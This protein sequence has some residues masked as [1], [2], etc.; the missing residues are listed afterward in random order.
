[1]K[2]R[3]VSPWISALGVVVVLGLCGLALWISRPEPPRE[4]APEPE[5]TPVAVRELL[6]AE[7]LRLLWIYGDTEPRRRALPAAERSGR[8]VWRHEAL[9]TGGRVEAGEEILR[10]ERKPAELELQDAEAGLAMARARAEQ[11]RADRDGLARSLENARAR[12]ALAERELERQRGLAASGDTAPSVV[13]QTEAAWLAAA[14]RVEQLE[15]QLASAEAALAVA[16]AGVAQARARLDRAQ[17]QLERTVLHAPFRGEVRA[18]RA[19]VG[20]LLLPGSVVCEV[21]DRRSLRL[22]GR[23]PNEDSLGLDASRA[24]RVRFPALLDARG[25]ALEAPGRILG[26]DPAAA[27]LRHRELLI[28]VDN[29]DLRL[30]AGAFAEIGVDLGRE[31]ALWI[32]PHEYVVRGGSPRAFVA[33]AEGD[34]VRARERRLRLGR[35]LVD[36]AGRTW[37]PVRDGLAAHDLLVVDNLEVLEDGG[38][39]SL[40]ERLPAAAEAPPAGPP[41]AAEPPGD[42]SG[43]G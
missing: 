7:R 29:P 33:E 23:I 26:L 41:L 39:L 5:P 32:R 4:Q 35:P 31:E 14:D 28:E 38:L 10:L 9:E 42:G 34:I 15:N 19:E 25:E 21:V 13:D 17:D 37:F 11:A 20:D 8:V 40:V 24:V 3:H 36:E 16:E 22:R 18:V 6:P 27:S 12:A 1:M 43:E 30:P 2:R